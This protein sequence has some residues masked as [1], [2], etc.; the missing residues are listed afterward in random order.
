MAIRQED[1]FTGLQALLPPPTRRGL[2]IIDPAYE[3]KRDYG[4]VVTALKEGLKRFATGTYLIWYPLLQ[5]N[6]SLQ[7]ADRLKKL[8]P[9]WLS[10][11]LSVRAPAPEGLGMHGSG[12]FIV[13]PPWTLAASL[14]ETLPWLADILA[15]DA[16]KVGA[17]WTAE[18]ASPPLPASP[19][20]EVTKVRR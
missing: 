12:V 3:D 18:T 8:A 16:E 10:V 9:D 5:R 11:T 14:K 7:L 4:R 6:E 2:I 15:T 17:G 13:N 1:G 20:G 19:R